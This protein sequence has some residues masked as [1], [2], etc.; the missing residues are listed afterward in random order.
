MKV[1][2]YQTSPELLDIEKN[3]EDIISK[4]RDGRE[5]GAELIVFPEM[6]LTG[7]F[8]GQRYHEVALRMDS[9]EIE[10]LAKATKGTAAVIGFIEESRSMNFYNSAPVSYTHLTLPTKR[11]V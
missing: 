1:A 4:I 6:A 10:R 3:M 8:V 7:Y 2:V 9:Q 11:I 5:R